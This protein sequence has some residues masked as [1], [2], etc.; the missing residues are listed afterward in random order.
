VPDL[1][2]ETAYTCRTNIYW[3]TKVDSSRITKPPYTVRWEVTPEK[4]AQYGWTCTCPHY[5]HRQTPCRHIRQVMV[6]G[7]RCGWNAALDPG[8]EPVRPLEGEPT[9]PGCGGPVEAV[10]VGV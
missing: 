7:Q 5:Q 9:C 1:T 6:S 8:V 3:S 4:E 2:I 10:R